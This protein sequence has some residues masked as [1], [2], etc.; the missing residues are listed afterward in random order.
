MTR[1]GELARGVKV[2]PIR[3]TTPLDSYYQTAEHI[4]RQVRAACGSSGQ[5]VER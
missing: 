1:A 5:L 4:L 2:A 3:Q